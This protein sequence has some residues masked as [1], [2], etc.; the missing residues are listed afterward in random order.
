MRKVILA[1]LSTIGVL[2]L[3]LLMVP[4][5]FKGE[6]TE[7]IKRELEKKLDVTISFH[8]LQLSMLDNFP[9]MSVDITDIVLINKQKSD[10]LAHIGH[11]FGDINF[12]SLIKGNSYIINH[13]LIEN[14]R[15]TIVEDSVNHVSSDRPDKIK[16]ESE[17]TS[18]STSKELDLNDISL[19]NITIHYENLKDHSRLECNDISLKLSGKL[20]K[21]NSMLNLHLDIPA[22]NYYQN[23]ATLFRD[24][25]INWEADVIADFLSD[26]YTMKENTL[27]LN[28][29]PL[30]LTGNIKAAKEGWMLDLQANAPGSDF[31]SCFE[32]L[33]ITLAEKLKPY[34]TK[35]AFT[36]SAYIK[37]LMTKT[38]IPQFEAILRV[39]NGSMKYPSFDEMISAINLDLTI[40]NPG[41]VIDSTCITLEKLGFEVGGSPFFASIQ[42][43]N[44]N[45]W[46]ING[47]LKGVLDFD[48]LKRAIP[49]DSATLNGQVT[50]D[51]VLDGYYRYIEQQEYDR[52]KATGKL[53]FNNM[54]FKNKAFPEGISIK[55]GTMLVSPERLQLQKLQTKLYSS[56]VTLEG[57]LANYIPYFIKHQQLKG[58]FNL[59]SP[60]INLN[61]I[62]IRSMQSNYE[63][64]SN[65]V[66]DSTIDHSI[67]TERILVIPNNIDLSIMAKVD[68]L[69]YDKM[70]VTNLKGSIQLAE[71]VAD[72][73]NLSMNMLNGS[74]VM[75]GQYS[76][77]KI[78]EP[79]LSLS[80]K[81]T[82]F[83][84]HELYKS[85]SFIRKN[86][87]FAINCEGQ[88]SAAFEF[89]T[90]LDKQMEIIPSTLNGNGFLASRGIIINHNGTLDA[91]SAIVNSDELKQLTIAQ[92]KID[93]DIVE[94]NIHIEPFTTNFVGNKLTMSGDQTVNGG[95]N[96]MLSLDIKRK[97][98]GRE[99][100][101]L[102]RSIP[103]S[104]NI[105]SL[106]IEVSITG[107]LDKPEVK[108]NLTKA[109]KQVTSEAVKEFN[110]SSGNDIL[111]GLK[112]LFQ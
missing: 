78:E 52:F 95:L 106:P 3:L 93:F 82:D 32:M 109:I 13:V 9:N 5:F 97:Y 81:V 16:K 40:T 50:M 98:F 48:A 11:V 36:F 68:R 71:S 58:N 6:I 100:E 46:F 26:S 112:K 76:S 38:I 44:P 69:L 30:S 57:Y 51:V 47:I 29:M 59:S 88:L 111:K 86:I 103:G 61:E 94:G 87:P 64:R 33:P 91:L 15:V 31:K 74:L 22:I 21:S 62:V 17:T 108:P 14:G 10:T 101:K 34:E 90:K 28:G 73:K 92:L 80:T 49:L 54:L 66:S 37:G 27:Y 12:G 89:K 53:T 19:E 24:I 56:N 84:I 70:I 2:V 65:T 75:N 63:N 85:F 42:L 99:V 45:D 7:L 39:D 41:G 67:P 60:S 25:K 8:S 35:G 4:L 20:A 110:K 105:S 18:S 23:K 55:S 102:L 96:Y 1:V 107:T 43:K 77:R 72:L 79:T 83:D 104:G